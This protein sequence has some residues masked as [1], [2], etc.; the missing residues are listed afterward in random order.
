MAPLGRD[1]RLHPDQGAPWTL[2]GDDL[3]RPALA[4][5]ERIPGDLHLLPPSAD[6]SIATEARAGGNDGERRA[7]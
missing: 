5:M 7:Q 1:L 4:A 3:T 6:G 2:H